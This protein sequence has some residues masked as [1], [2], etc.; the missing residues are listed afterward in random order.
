MALLMATYPPQYG[1]VTIGNG[2]AGHTISI[3]GAGPSGAVLTSNGS[4]GTTWAATA[5]T[6]AQGKLHLEGKDADIVMNGASLKEILDGITD[7]LSILQPK[8][9]LLE[10]YDNLREA[11][12]HYKTLEKLLTEY[13]NDK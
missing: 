10:K 2:G 12:E 6:T 11:Y 9:E 8:P 5:K 1:N 3:A 13:N 7:R 4:T